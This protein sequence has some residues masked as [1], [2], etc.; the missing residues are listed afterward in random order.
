[1]SEIKKLEKPASVEEFKRY[2]LENFKPTVGFGSEFEKIYTLNQNSLC[3]KFEA[4]DFWKEFILSTKEIDARYR[5]D[6]N[7]FD[8][9][10]HPDKIKIY[11]K[12]V[13]EAIEKAY[14]T[15]IVN[16]EFPFE[17]SEYFEQFVLPE[18]IFEKL[19]DI[20]RT[21]IIVKYIDGIDLV[22]AFLENLSKK[23]NFKTKVEPKSK[24][25]GYFAK[26]LYISYKNKI[27]DFESQPKEIEHT[28]EIQI[29]TQLQDTIKSILH[30]H[31]EKDR[32]KYQKEQESTNWRWQF[33]ESRFMTNYIGHILH[34]FDGIIVKIKDQK[35]D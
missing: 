31:Y 7:E 26:H 19:N 14:R 20:I 35:E 1:M 18:N 8:L 21:E 3:D 34:F 10:L 22:I 28:F 16:N 25:E 12:G 29:R 2:I 27:V 30:N 33:K 4:S 17:S 9:I 11:K 23:Y 5:K 6:N 15:S 32:I 13:Q 24:E